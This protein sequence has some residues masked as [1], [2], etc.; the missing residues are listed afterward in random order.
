MRD[1]AQH[2]AVGA[3]ADVAG[4]DKARQ[5]HRIHRPRQHAMRDPRRLQV[6]IAKPA[7]TAAIITADGKHFLPPQQ[8]RQPRRSTIATTAAAAD[9]TGS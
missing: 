3:L 9:S 6:A 5:R 4:L 7:A 1:D 2:E 8:K